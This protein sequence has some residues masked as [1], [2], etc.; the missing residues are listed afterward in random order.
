MNTDTPFSIQALKSPLHWIT[1]LIV[2]VID[3]A[4]K[5]YIRDNI[6]EGERGAT[7][8]R[9]FFDIIHTQNKGAAFGMFNQ[10][11]PTFRMLFFTAIT[12]I[13]L[14][15]LFY[16]LGTSPIKEKLQRFAIALI[17]GGAFGNVIDR[18]WF[19]Q[20]TD[21]L[22]VYISNSHWPAF[23]VADSAISV[24]VSLIFLK[25]IPESFGNFFGRK[26]KPKKR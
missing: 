11:S 20:V 17:L 18:A 15:L 23:N 10:A 6:A 21:F 8:I 26:R 16:W 13:C 24:G 9:G 3:Q 1:I 4:T 2:V 5:V 7:I 25:L 12:I 22:D 19:G 14:G